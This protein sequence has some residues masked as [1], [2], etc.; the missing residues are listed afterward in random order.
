MTLSTAIIL[1]VLLWTVL[2]VVV[3]LLF[4]AFCRGGK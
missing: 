2:S 1:T 3:G 4:A